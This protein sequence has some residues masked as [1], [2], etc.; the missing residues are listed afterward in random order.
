MQKQTFAHVLQNKC[1]QQFRKIQRTTLA[2]GSLFR[3]SRDITR[4][5]SITSSV[6]VRSFPF[7]A[8]VY[9]EVFLKLRSLSKLPRN[10]VA[11]LRRKRFAPTS[12]CVETVKHFFRLKQSA[13]LSAFGTVFDFYYLM[14]SALAKNLEL[15][16][17]DQLPPT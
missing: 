4:E 5:F 1:S 2:S 13:F 10:P 9:I 8:C 17:K 11:T 3:E 6:F 14:C 15:F 7:S 12:P 16:Q